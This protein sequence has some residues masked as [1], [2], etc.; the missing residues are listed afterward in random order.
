VIDHFF[1]NHACDD[2]VLICK[3]WH[4][5]WLAFAGYA[6]VMALLFVPLFKHRHDPAAAGR[7]VPTH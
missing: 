2:S 1:T 6:L 5:I 4:G 3:D 7:V